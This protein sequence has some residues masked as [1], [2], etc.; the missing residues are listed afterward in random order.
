MLTVLLL[1]FS[2]GKLKPQKVSKPNNKDRRGEEVDEDEK[3]AAIVRKEQAAAGL[4]HHI[5]MLLWR[6]GG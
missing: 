4:C 5:Y 6:S 1:L 2:G 3:A